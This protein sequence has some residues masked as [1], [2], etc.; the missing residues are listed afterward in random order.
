MNE[1]INLAFGDPLIYLDCNQA[2]ECLHE[3]QLPDWK[4]PPNPSFS[5]LSIVIMSLSAILM[6]IGAFWGLSWLKKRD[7][8][9]G[10][11]DD[12]R[13]LMDEEEV[14]EQEQHLMSNHT[15]STLCFS[16]ICYSIPQHSHSLN[17]PL[18]ST[19][20]N[21]SESNVQIVLKDIK[22]FVCP[23][24]LLAIMGGSGA[25]KT[26]FLD[27]LARKNKRGTISGEIIVNGKIMDIQEYKSII[28]YVFFLSQIK[29]C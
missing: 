2:G 22:G 17:F 8:R 4:P 9:L 6:V 13:H 29:V 1:L 5:T 12:R 26:T 27:I 18:S 15:P 28:G 10:D 20:Q 21:I 11:E 19:P 24:E 7:G 16:N 3:S 25:G 23:G 14:R